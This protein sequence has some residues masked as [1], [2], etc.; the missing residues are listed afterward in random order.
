MY[1][2]F[3]ESGELLDSYE[4]LETARICRESIE[5]T[6]LMYGNV[7]VYPDGEAPGIDTKYI[8]WLDLPNGAALEEDFKTMEEALNCFGHRMREYPGAKCEEIEERTSIYHKV[9]I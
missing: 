5:D 3:T 9:K 8:Y 1:K 6:K 7:E 2:L 4:D